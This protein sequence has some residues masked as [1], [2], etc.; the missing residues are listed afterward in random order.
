MPTPTGPKTLLVTPSQLTAYVKLA[1]TTKRSAQARN[2]P[3]EIVLYLDELMITDLERV[4]KY[5]ECKVDELVSALILRNFLD[6]SNVVELVHG[7]RQ[8]FNFQL[9]NVDDVFL[10]LNYARYTKTRMP[11]GTGK[12]NSQLHVFATMLPI[13]T[14]FCEELECDINEL[15]TALVYKNFFS[16]DELV[17]LQEQLVKHLRR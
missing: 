4:S 13:I 12:F 5:L 2:K 7:K 10:L 11:N 8:A 9:P 14:R 17:H 15:T 3:F 16:E 6:L 1:R